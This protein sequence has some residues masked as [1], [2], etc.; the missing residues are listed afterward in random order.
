MEV[1]EQQAPEI[2]VQWYHA[3]PAELLSSAPVTLDPTAWQK[4]SREESNA[5]EGVWKSLSSEEQATAHQFIEDELQVPSLDEDDNDFLGVPVGTDKL[6]E[7][8]LYP[9]F[10]RAP[11][12]PIKVRRCVWMYDEN[13]AVEPALSRELEEAYQYVPHSSYLPSQWGLTHILYLGSQIKP[14]LPSYPDEVQAALSAGTL[15]AQDKLKTV[16]QK[17]NHSAVF[18][19][20]RSARIFQGTTPPSVGLFSWGMGRGRGGL[21]PGATVVWRGIE[22]AEEVTAAVAATG[23]GGKDKDKPSRPALEGRRLSVSSLE[24]GANKRQKLEVA[25]DASRIRRPGVHPRQSEDGITRSES[26]ASTKSEG[27]RPKKVLEVE[28]VPQDEDTVVT[29]LFL[30]IHGIGQGYT[31]QY[32]AWDFTKQSQSPALSSIMRNRRAQFL[33]IPWRASMKLELDEERRREQEGLDNHFTLA[34]ITPK[35][36]IPYVRE[37]TNNVLIDIPYFMSQHRDRMIESVCLTANRAYRLWCARNPDFESHGRVHLLAHSLGSALSA[38][39]LSA[40][41]TI[42]RPLPDF[43][44]E[45]LN[46]MNSQF[47]FN[48]SHMFMIGSPLG[49]FMHINQ[50]QLIARKGRERTMD[51]REDEALDRT[52]RFGCL[53]VDA[54]YNI[55]NP[56]DPI[57]YLLNP[58]VDSEFAKTMKQSTIPSVG[59]TTLATLGSRITKMFDG[60]ALPLSGSRAA[61]PAPKSRAKQEESME[62]MDLGGED[63]LVGQ[64]RGESRA[65]RRFRALNP[66]GTIDF[67]LPSEGTISDYVDMITAHGDY[68]A[69]S[70]LATFVLTEIFARKEDLLRTGMSLGVKG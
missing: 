1:D 22:A 9:V 25:P 63:R 50:A 66:H 11:G 12:P 35:K 28:P 17:S 3:G 29:D 60:F 45:E 59:T 58:C 8:N 24:E 53:A 2:Y 31:A 15:E 21:F 20:A 42:Q 56:S 49:I 54:L 30:I 44:Q 40:Q 14:Y 41:P 65:E 55:F 33:P 37:L 26:P 43:T 6:F 19:D 36:S 69:D 34:D 47:L 10:W 32:E 23:A 13:R 38:H 57:A 4:L 67:A 5:C 27:D 7:I 39:I 18:Q 68:W 51:A 62:A 52:G 16:L 61:S 64:A 70:S 46:S 48:T